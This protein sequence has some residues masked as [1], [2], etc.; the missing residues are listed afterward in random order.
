[1]LVKSVCKHLSPE[2][3]V[4]CYILTKRGKVELLNS[5][6]SWVCLWCKWVS[7]PQVAGSVQKVAWHGGNHVSFLCTIGYEMN[8]LQHSLP[9][10]LFT[11]WKRTHL[12]KMKIETAFVLSL[13]IYSKIV[14]VSARVCVCVW[15]LDKVFNFVPYNKILT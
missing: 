14:I 6:E 1:M 9:Q 12:K 7:C 2:C 11:V 10:Y 15:Y 5:V 4:T 13:E 3:E 8:W